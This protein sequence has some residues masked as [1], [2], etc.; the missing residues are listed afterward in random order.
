MT[1]DMNKLDIK[2]L[3]TAIMYGLLKDIDVKTITNS[4]LTNTEEHK[5]KNILQNHLKQLIA[6]MNDK[7]I[8]NLH[9]IPETVNYIKKE[10]YERF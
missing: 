10:K 1:L 7:E 5:V 3:A 2:D 4:S 6:S 8:I 9:S